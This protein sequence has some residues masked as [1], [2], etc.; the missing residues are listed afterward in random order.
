VF[1]LRFVKGQVTLGQVSNNGDPMQPV[2]IVTRPAPDGARFAAQCGDMPVILSPLQRIDPIEANC[3]ARGAIFTS[4]NG[5]AQAARLG[6]TSGPAWCV[7]DRTAQLA[8]DAGFDAVSAD[9]DVEN[10]MALIFAA[11]PDVPVAHIRGNEARGDIGPRLRAA[12]IDCSDCIAY[13]QTP[14]DLTPSAITAIRGAHPVIIPL[15]S[16]RAARL[17]SEQIA[18]GDH[19]TLVAISPAVAE[20]CK[21]RTVTAQ[22]PNGQAMLDTV[23]ILS[24]TM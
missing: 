1:R 3:T 21:A 24:A 9:G 7:G 6:L 11:P 5:V 19:V 22:R 2:L 12:G 23:R 17:L 13:L 10:L 4:S 16:P 20:L 14:L 8:R 18:L 15:F